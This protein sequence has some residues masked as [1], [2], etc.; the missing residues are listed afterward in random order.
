[1]KLFSALTFHLTA[2]HTACH[3][4]ASKM[5]A[6]PVL[7]LDSNIRPSGLRRIRPLVTRTFSQRTGQC[8]DG[9]GLRA[10]R[11]HYSPDLLYLSIFFSSPDF[12][13]FPFFFLRPLPPLLAAAGDH[14]R[15]YYLSGWCSL[16]YALFIAS[17]SR[18]SILRCLSSCRYPEM[19]FPKIMRTGGYASWGLLVPVYLITIY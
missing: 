11:L 10:K 2:T 19:L 4:T 8:G 14:E 15:A 1:M 17:S 18:F 9:T 3:K 13:F 7:L 5:T 12:A 16:L 6:T